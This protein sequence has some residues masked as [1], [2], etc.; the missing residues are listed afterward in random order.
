MTTDPLLDAKGV[1]KAY[2]AVAALRNAS[3]SVLPSPT[4][5]RSAV[6]A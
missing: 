4:P 5:A 1:A 3:L 2:G 6:R